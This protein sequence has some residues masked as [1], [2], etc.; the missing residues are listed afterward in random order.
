[1]KRLNALEKSM[2]EMNNKFNTL[3]SADDLAKFLTRAELEDALQGIRKDFESKLPNL[4]DF[5]H[6]VTWAGLEDALQGI[7]QDW[8]N[9]QQPTLTERV[10]IEMSS[11]TDPVK[12]PHKPSRPTSSRSVTRGGSPG[13]SGALLEILEKL[14]KLCESHAELTKRVEVLEAEMKKKLDQGALDGLNLSSELLGQLQELKEQVDALAA[15]REKDHDALLKLQDENREEFKKLF[16]YCDELQENKADRTEVDVKADKRSLDNKV[17]HSLFDTTTNDISRMIKEILDKMAGNEDAW[18]QQCKVFSD[19]IEGKLDRLELDPLKEWLM[20]RL[21]ALNDKLKKQNQAPVEWTDDDAAGI[22]RQLIQKYHCIS[23]DRPIDIVPTGPVPSM[24]SVSNHQALHPTRS[25]RPYLTFELDQI[26]QHAQRTYAG[27]DRPGSR[28]ANAEIADYY[29]TNRSCGGQ[30][31]TTFP[32][33]RLTK[34]SHLSNTIIKED[35]ET[36]IYP[37]YKEEINVQGA[38]GNIYK[39][40]MDC[41]EGKLPPATQKTLVRN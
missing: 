4:D 6:F 27:I 41:L 21:K 1:M 39:G 16:A 33:K 14:G 23:C 25:P 11:Q 7:R 9:L 35:G 19:D 8:E 29:A 18:N 28:Y 38:D 12:R 32:H 40:R 30:H 36:N 5:A 10:V 24:P 26:R 13:P 20:S 31:T 34:M 2:N 15:A 22:R 17:N 37:L 3:P